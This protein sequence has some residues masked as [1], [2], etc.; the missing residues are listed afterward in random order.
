MTFEAFAAAVVGLIRMEYPS[1]PAADLASRQVD[2]IGKSATLRLMPADD[3]HV[4]LL[5]I[6]PGVSIAPATH[7]MSDRGA[8]EIAVAVAAT[9]GSVKDQAQ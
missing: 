7:P 2:W 4:T 3:E 8:R 9:F 1:L 6:S 5:L